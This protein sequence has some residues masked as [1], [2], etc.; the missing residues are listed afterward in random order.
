MVALDG[1]YGP[2]PPQLSG[3][4]PLTMQCPKCL[5]TTGAQC[6]GNNGHTFNKGHDAR[7]KL[8]HTIAMFRFSRRHGK[9][10][11]KGGWGMPKV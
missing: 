4:E 2:K 6:V 9:K 10:I 11:A 5:A 3:A 7:R 8:A 1:C